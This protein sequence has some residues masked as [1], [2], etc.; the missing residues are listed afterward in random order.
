MVATP[1]RDGVTSLEAIYR[2]DL[3]VGRSV[4]GARKVQIDVAVVCYNTRT[5]READTKAEAI[6]ITHALAI[7]HMLLKIIFGSVD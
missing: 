3:D 2:W 5:T 7:M 4:L 6:I 1:G